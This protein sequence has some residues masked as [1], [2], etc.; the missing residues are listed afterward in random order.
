MN[1]TAE[2]IQENWKEFTAYIDVYIQSPRREKLQEFYKKFEEDL[3]LMPASHK[4]AYHNAFPGGYIDHVNRVIRGALATAR[5]WEEFGVEKNY[6]EEELVF[7]AM[8]HDLGKMGNGEEVAYL[9]SQDDWRKK[10]L[11]E[12]YQ[13]NKKLTY[14]SVPDRS[15]KLL[16]DNG[17]NLTENEWMTIKLH[18]GLYDQANEPYL[19][20]FMPEQKPRTSMVFIIHQADLMAARIEFEKVWL[21][22]FNEEV[23]NKP[24]AKKLD[25]KTKALG[26]MKSEGLKNMLN[27][28]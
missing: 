18:D 16:I 15:I 19:K 26:S 11:G 23:L 25:V 14:M 3:I 27:S 6:T 4:T 12:M 17:I 7:S 13:Y 1:L 9:P 5:L 24:K 8:N 28:L 21:S 2:Q 10:N 22:K 20:S